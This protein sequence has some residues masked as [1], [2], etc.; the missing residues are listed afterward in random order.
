MHPPPQ[1]SYCMKLLQDADQDVLFWQKETA[2]AEAG[3]THASVA[4]QEWGADVVND[5]KGVTYRELMERAECWLKEASSEAKRR[6]ARKEMSEQQRDEALVSLK[7]V[8]FGYVLGL[9]WLCVRSLLTL[10][11]RSCRSNRPRKGTLWH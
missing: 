10:L 7:Q 4:L 5:E 9:F 2:E 6:L 3:L 8:S 1:V 11:R